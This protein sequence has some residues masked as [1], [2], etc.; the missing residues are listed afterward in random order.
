VDQAITLLRQRGRLTYRTLQRQFQLDDAALD[1]LK[2]ELIYGQHLAVDEEGRVLVWTGGTS[3]AP[4]SLSPVP[5]PATLDVS[6]TRSEAHPSSLLR[7]MPNV[8]NS[9]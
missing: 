6:P 7:L 8:D 5:P 2:D 3:S 9:R 4:V 1:D